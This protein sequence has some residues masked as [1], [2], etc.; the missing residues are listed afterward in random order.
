MQPAQ[1]SYRRGPSPS[2]HHLMGVA[3]PSLRSVWDV[4]FRSPY[5]I[6]ISRF[7][8]LSKRLH[9]ACK[10]GANENTNGVIRQDLPKRTRISDVSR[11]I[12]MRSSARSTPDRRSSFRTL[13][14][15]HVEAIQTGTSESAE[16]LRFKLEVRRLW[17][18]WGPA[19]TPPVN[20][21]RGAHRSRLWTP[22]FE[23]TQVEPVPQEPPLLQE[24]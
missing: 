7:L 22:C 15:C 19:W 1:S 14:E 5:R 8:P 16:V 17:Q 12:L 3:Q 6:G 18:Q 23:A 9:A 21:P 2:P 20:C 4:M 13:E 11:P 24:Q 10:R